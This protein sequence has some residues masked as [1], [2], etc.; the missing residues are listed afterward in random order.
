MSAE[1]IDS[2]A[3]SA[4]CG[5]GSSNQ[6]PSG[7]SIDQLCLSPLAPPCLFV[8]CC[9]SRDKNAPSP[10]GVDLVSGLTILSEE[11]E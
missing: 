4:F 11:F 6:V 10:S 2:R 7:D 1:V 5:E 9:L 3:F 8:R